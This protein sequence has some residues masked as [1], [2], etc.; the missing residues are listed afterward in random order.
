MKPRVESNA[1]LKTFLF[2]DKQMRFLPD[3]KTANIIKKSH[4]YTTNQK[5]L[6]ELL[7]KLEPLT[8]RT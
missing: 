6:F 2:A 3:F 4:N 5:E 7:L 8:I 1:S